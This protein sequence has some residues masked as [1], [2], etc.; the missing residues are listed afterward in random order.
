[1]LRSFFIVSG[2][3]LAVVMTS[4]APMSNTKTAKALKPG[5]IEVGLEFDS[6]G[7]G[8]Y[9]FVPGIRVGVLK[10][11]DA[12][13]KVA[14]QLLSFAV[15]VKYDFLNENKDFGLALNPTITYFS[16]KHEDAERFEQVS[17]GGNL[18][19]SYDIGYLM[20]L[21]AFTG[22]GYMYHTGELVSGDD[23]ISK[24]TKAILEDMFEGGFY[25]VGIGISLFP[26]E[27]ISLFGEVIGVY[28]GIG[29]SEDIMMIPYYNVAVK[30]RF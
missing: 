18:I 3:L 16:M 1:M 20:S 5:K 19:V 24:L 6:A 23:F 25:K 28:Y 15:D 8:G 27:P 14:P 2:V 29:V 22:G 17:F 4:C 9:S 13:V 11:M 30:V 7:E 21:V 26:N 10:G 12:G